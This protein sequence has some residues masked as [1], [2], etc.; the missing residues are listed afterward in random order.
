MMVMRGFTNHF[1]S[2]LSMR[3][4]DAVR[5]RPCGADSDGLIGIILYVDLFDVK[6]YVPDYGPVWRLS[7]QLEVIK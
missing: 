3:V 7:R 2:K 6:V 1:T 4:S 5:L